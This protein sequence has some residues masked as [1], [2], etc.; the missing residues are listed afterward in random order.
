MAA[1]DP[2]NSPQ[3]L[4]TTRKSYLSFQ[5]KDL[6]VEARG[7]CLTLASCTCRRLPAILFI[8]PWAPRRQWGL[9]GEIEE[10]DRVTAVPEWAKL[11]FE[12]TT[13]SHGDF[14]FP[15]AG[16]IGLP[17]GPWLSPPTNGFHL[18]ESV[19]GLIQQEIL[20]V[21]TEDD[22][23]YIELT[24]AGKD[25]VAGSISAEDPTPLLVGLIRLTINSY[26]APYIEPLWQVT[27]QRCRE[28]I[29]TTIIPFLSVLDWQQ[30]KS[31]FPK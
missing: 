27:Q 29:D 11:I 16:F 22:W 20:K 18:S 23:L 4:E 7:L 24:E 2:S 17:P 15:R 12:E 1:T 9:Q 31:S 26:P 21:Y 28:V 25:L 5:P 8:R 10:Q 6:S 13:H 19:Q 3:I 14:S 30:L